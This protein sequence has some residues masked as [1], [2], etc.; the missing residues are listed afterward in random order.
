MF[1]VVDLEQGSPEWARWRH[2]GIGRVGRPGA[3]GRK[4]VAQRRN[5]VRREGPTGANLGCTPAPRRA[6][7][8]ARPVRRAPPPRK[9]TSLEGR[10]RARF[11]ADHSLAC[12]P[13]CTQSI[14]RPWQR[15]SLDGIDLAARRALE[16]KCGPS[17]YA[18]VAATG[19]VPGHYT[20]QLQQTLAVTGFDAIDF[21]VWRPGRPPLHLEVARDEGF[22]ERLNDRSAA[23][24][25]RVVAARAA[26][27]AACGGLFPGRTQGADV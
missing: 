1:A 6:G 10:A 21:W 25:E 26:R 5:A 20:G 9:D 16:I 17:T 27:Q 18:Q 4:S 3:D 15:A 24:W 12:V 19:R 11:C 23:F 14:D 7:P 22:I 2:D 8:P 13:L